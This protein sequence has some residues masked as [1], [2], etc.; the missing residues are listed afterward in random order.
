[1]GP[2]AADAVLAGWA[3]SAPKPCNCGAP[4]AWSHRIG[5][6]CWGPVSVVDDVDE[7]AV[8]STWI[9][10]CQGH[11]AVWDGGPYRFE[12]L[13][14]LRADAEKAPEIAENEGPRA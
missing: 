5:E 8:G 10:A 4:C 2:G 3:V 14:I 11:E 13:Q 12:A 7:G 9:H 6:P 1:M